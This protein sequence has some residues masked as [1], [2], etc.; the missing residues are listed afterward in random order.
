LDTFEET[1]KLVQHLH[2]AGALWIAVH[3]RC[4]AMWDRK[5]QGWTFT[6]GTSRCN[7]GTAADDV[8]YFGVVY[9]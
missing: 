6:V 9:L 7:S 1:I 5:S 3:V 4:L 2:D 8:P